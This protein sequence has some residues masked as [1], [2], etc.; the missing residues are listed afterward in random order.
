MTMGTW[1]GLGNNVWAVKLEAGDEAAPGAQVTVTKKSG[2]KQ[3]ITLDAP[4]PGRDG[5]WTV[6]REWQQGQRQQQ[7]TYANDATVAAA[8]DALIA[9]LDADQR[10]VLTWNPGRNAAVVAT[11]GAGK[12]TTTV[13]LVADL[14]RRGVSPG[15]LVVTTFTNKAGKELEERLLKVLTRT[16]FDGIKV[17]TFHG[18]LRRQLAQMDANKWDMRYCVDANARTR[19]AQVSPS[20]TLWIRA[21]DSEPIGLLGGVAGMGVGKENVGEYRLAVEA[22]CLSKGLSHDT[23]A[24]REAAN[25]VALPRLHSAWGLYEEQK[26]A[27]RSWDFSDVLFAGREL[28]RS[29]YEQHERIVIVDE[30]QDNSTL[31]IELAR[32]MA[33]PRGNVLFVG[34]VRQSIYGWRGAAPDLFKDAPSS[35]NAQT[36]FLPN[37]YRSGKKIVELGN[38]VAEGQDWSVGPPAKAARN[39]DGEVTVTSYG[40]TDSCAE[41]VAREIAREVADGKRPDAFAVLCRTRAEQGSY[42][43]ALLVQRVP[44]AIV[45]GS[46]FFASRL[47]KDYA[48]VLATAS[49]NVDG[50][51]LRRAL[52]A[53]PA[54]GPRTADGVVA[55]FNMSHDLFAALKGAT[56]GRVKAK[57]VEALT[58]FVVFLK[59]LGTV[60]HRVRCTEVSRLL[61]SYMGNESGDS[62]ERGEMQ[63]AGAIAARF[64][65][66]R[67]ALAFAARCEGAALS[68]HDDASDE[69]AQGRVCIS[70]IHKAKGREWHTVYADVS[71]CRFPHIRCTGEK[72]LAEEQRLFYVT[73]TRAADRLRLSYCGSINGK[74]AGPSEFLDYVEQDSPRGGGIRKETA[75]QMEAHALAVMEKHHGADEVAAMLDDGF[76]SDPAGLLTPSTEPRQPVS[77]PLVMTGPSPA[78]LKAALERRVPHAVAQTIAGTQPEPGKRFVPVTFDEFTDLLSE[79]GF[80]EDPA[81][82]EKTGQRTLVSTLAG[83]VKVV[84]YSTIPEGCEVARELGEDSI[85]FGLLNADSKPLMKRQ[86]YAART[87][88]WRSTVISRLLEVVSRFGGP[89][90]D[91][92]GPSVEK[93]AKESGRVYHSCVRFPDCK[94]YGRKVSSAA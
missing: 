87:K 85:R 40:D 3:T 25:A 50:D 70:T 31:Q 49:G 47:W 18:L 34:D 41:G 55:S 9:R 1:T 89:C 38:R 82:T 30:A 26:R 22:E 91:C 68:L 71:A 33:G 62:D 66:V 4:V 11:A 74:P 81:L 86:P 8:R 75:Q 21:C 54:V 48:A 15:A 36:F 39:V 79:A 65:D 13:A 73:V 28:L 92:G 5:V 51:T 16:Q 94:G 37:N 35:M 52:L 58:S 12:T 19:S 6:R 67:E 23:E 10:S 56:V 88:N 42:E 61:C 53:M 17:G 77:A 76:L 27:Q 64:A 72:Q 45:G 80:A 7:R 84:V 69:A 44:V 59:G 2:E 83:G 63:A 24:G 29:E 14:L 90:E 57:T 43:A 20:S 60:E 32:L 93:Q 46:S 78:D